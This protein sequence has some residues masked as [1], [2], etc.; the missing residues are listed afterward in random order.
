M[1]PASPSTAVAHPLV[2]A[3]ASVQADFAS[4][5]LRQSCDTLAVASSIPFPVNAQIADVDRAGILRRHHVARAAHVQYRWLKVAAAALLRVAL[6]PRRPID[7]AVPAP[8]LRRSRPE[9]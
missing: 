2:R 5:T 6:P 9:R 4:S 3:T 1:P 7:D 8:G